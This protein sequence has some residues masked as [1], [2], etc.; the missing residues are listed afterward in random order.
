M[1]K[2]FSF[3]NHLFLATGA[4][5]VLVDVHNAIKENYEAVILG[6]IDYSRV[7]PALKIDEGEYQ[8][9][10][11]IFFLKHSIL[12]VHQRRLAIVFQ[13]IDWLFHLDLIVIYVHHNILAGKKHFS[14]FPKHIITISDRCIQNLTDYFGV[15]S[16]NITKIFNSVPDSYKSPHQMSKDGIIRILYPATVYPVKRQIQV[17]QHLKENLPS[18]IEI[19]FAGDG[20]DLEEL[21]KLTKDDNRIKCLGFVNDVQDRL[22]YVDYCMLFSEYEGLPISLIE[23]TM[24]GVPIIC[25]DVGG[26]LEIAIG[27]QNAFICNTWEELAECISNLHNVSEEDYSRMCSNSRMHYLNNFT[28]GI[29]KEKYNKYVEEIENGKK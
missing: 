1:I 3:D 22:E 27:G 15:P 6:T 13:F 11:S 20:Q 25:N 10:K 29:F 17:Y 2:V 21:K 26:N 28:T 24:K 14:F 9:L 18:N 19:L 7:N 8:K 5:K 4:H 12:F 23:A 16:N